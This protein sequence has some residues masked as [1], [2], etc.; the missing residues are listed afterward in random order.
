MATFILETTVWLRD[1]GLI[2]Q[3]MS[4]K[5]SKTFHWYVPAAISDSRS[6]EIK[7]V[8]LAYRKFAIVCHLYCNPVRG[9]TGCPNGQYR[10]TTHYWRR[11]RPLLLPFRK[12][13]ICGY[14]HYLLF[15]FLIYAPG[16]SGCD[17]FSEKN[18]SNFPFPLFL[19][20]DWNFVL[21]SCKTTR[22]FK[23]IMIDIIKRWRSQEGC[24]GSESW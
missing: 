10:L 13:A 2:L 1:A 22:K 23:H 14:V 17:F 7:W 24:V 12:S 8:A 11:E 15:P 5:D 9:R 3:F 20:G 6:G 19:P 21:D 16:N 18:L 4:G